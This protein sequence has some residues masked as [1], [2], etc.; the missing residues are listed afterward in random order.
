MKAFLYSVSLYLCALLFFV[1]LLLRLMRV[2]RD[3]ITTHKLTDKIANRHRLLWSADQ[4]PHFLANPIDIV[5]YSKARRHLVSTFTHVA[6]PLSRRS[7]YV[8]RN[9]STTAQRPAFIFPWF[10][11]FFARQTASDAVK[12][13]GL[14]KSTASTSTTDSDWTH[15]FTGR[16]DV[17][18]IP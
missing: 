3:A 2:P 5:P 1:F 10:F 12:F 4:T 6:F 17:N 9:T 13:D 14:E 8:R 11:Y 7:S 15:S 18:Y 16:T